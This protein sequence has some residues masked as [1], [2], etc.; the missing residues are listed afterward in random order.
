MRHLNRRSTQSGVVLVIGLML[1]LIITIVAVAS[2]SSTHMQERMAGNARTQALAFEVA[3]AGASNSLAFFSDNRESVPLTACSDSASWEDNA[4]RASALDRIGFHD[5][6]LTQHLY[7]LQRFDDDPDAPLAPHYFVLSTGEV[8]A[9]S[10]PIARRALEVRIEA[11][12]PSTVGESDPDCGALCFL[13]C[14]SDSTYLFPRSNAFYVDG[15]ESPAITTAEAC[16]QTVRDAIQDNRIGNYEGGI[17]GVEGELAPPWTSPETVDEFRIELLRTM[18]AN[19]E[20]PFFVDA[21]SASAGD[22][23]TWQFINPSSGTFSD[24]GNTTYGT[25]DNP[26]ITY[27]AGNANMSG[28]VSGAGILVVEGDLEW[29]GTPP[30]EGLILVLGGKFQVSGGGIGGDFAG[31]LVVVDIWSNYPDHFYDKPD[32]ATYLRSDFGPIE[33]DF[34]GG[35]TALYRYDCDY[36]AGLSGGFGLGESWN[37]QCAGDDAGGEDEIT[38]VP[39]RLVSWRENIGWRVNLESWSPDLEE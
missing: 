13:G 19:N 24:A 18:G 23:S 34:R 5:V 22:G 9:G 36:L 3:S 11:Q 16:R 33:L 17:S 8:L 1:L 38:E 15:N 39:P 6:R 21:D 30:F 25:R 26:Q 2:M 28:T 32:I 14:D 20:G 10:T 27:I 35:G 12:P 29:S 4:F 7:C 37:P 31:S